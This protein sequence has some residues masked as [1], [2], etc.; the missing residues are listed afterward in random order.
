MKSRL[1]KF[2]SF[3]IAFCILT[4]CVFHAS[5]AD[6]VFSSPNEAAA[7][8]RAG[9]AE[10][11]SEISFSYNA[12][13]K[14]IG[15]LND[16]DL[17]RFFSSLKDGIEDKIFIHTG[18]GDEGDYLMNHS[19]KQYW[20]FVVFYEPT[21]QTVTYDI[22]VKALYYTTADQENAVTK[23]VTDALNKLDLNNKSDYRKVCAITGFIRDWVTYD[24]ARMNDPFYDLKYSAYAAIIN[25]T[26]VCQGYASLFYRMA[27]EAGLD[28]RII[29]GMAFNGKKWEQHEWNIVKID[30]A[31]YNIDMTWIDTANSPDYFLKGSK[32]FKA[33]YAADP[34]YQSDE[35]GYRVSET[36]YV[37][38]EPSGLWNENQS[39]SDQKPVVD[40]TNIGDVD[41]DKTV[42]ASDARL[43]LRAAVSLEKL[44][45]TQTA[46][47]DADRD[48]KVTASDA[49]LILRAAVS[50]EDR[51]TWFK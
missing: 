22:T 25:K 29:I 1:T 19:D 4:C 15:D 50:L 12:G 13:K 37:T 5:A 31:Y 18:K 11:K 23:A 8:I 16:I 27:L 17:K 44:T 9:M 47:A 10:R 14:E 3:F 21:A 45:V 7:F 28:C 42:T 38:N 33:E 41:G 20:S 49:R 34:F 51:K 26:A 40:H 35:F 48:G 24:L 46:L 32:S 6:A 43:A 36:D 39:G 2:F 30:G